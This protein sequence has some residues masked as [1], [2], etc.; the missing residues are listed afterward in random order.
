MKFWNP[1]IPWIKEIKENYNIVLG[2]GQ[3]KLPGKIVRIGH[4]GWVEK[5][6]IEDSINALKETL[7]KR[8]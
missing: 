5:K 4:M 2:G 1:W 7:G 8:N 3:Q 6:D